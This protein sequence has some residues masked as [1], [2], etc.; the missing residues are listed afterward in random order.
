MN[1][2]ELVESIASKLLEVDSLDQKRENYLK[3]KSYWA[4]RRER[5]AK[6]VEGRK[7]IEDASKESVSE[8]IKFWSDVNK[9]LATGLSLDPN[10]IGLENTVGKEWAVTH[11][12]KGVGKFP[13]YLG[14]GS[15]L[16]QA[17]ADALGRVPKQKEKPAGVTAPMQ[18]KLF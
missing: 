8:D 10:H 12:P 6:R 4:N 3:S 17:F 11:N 18:G 15:T 13:N 9:E 5:D 1:Y 14:K 16:Q 2:N 7:K